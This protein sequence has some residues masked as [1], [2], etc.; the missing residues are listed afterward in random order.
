MQSRRKEEHVELSRTV[1]SRG[2]HRAAAEAGPHGPYPVSR[3]EVINN[4]SPPLRGGRSYS[5]NSLDA[6]RRGGSVRDRMTGSMMGRDSYGQHL[7]SVTTETARSKSPLREQMRKKPHYEDEGV[8]HRK[9]DYVEPVG[10]DDR[11][12]SRARG[13]YHGTSRMTKEKDYMDNRVST[14]DGHVMMSQ[15]L[16]PVEE[17]NVRGPHRLPQD[18][19]TSLNF[20]ET[21]G[22]LPFSS[23]DINIGQYEHEK[24]RHRETIPSKKATVMDSY[25][26]DKPMFDSQDVTYSMVEAS[27]SKDFMSTNQLKDF[28]STSSGLPRTEF[29]CSYQ[30]DA[31]LHVSEEYLRSS[32]KLTE[33]VGYNKYDQ[34]PLT[35]SV[36]DPESARRNMTLYQQ[37]TNSPSRAEYEDYVYRKPRV[38]GS[39]NHGYPV[40]DV[41]RMMPSQ[42]R[43]SYEHASVDYGHIGM[44]KPNIMHH[45]VDRIDNTDHSYGSSRKAIIWDDHALQK[46]IS[47]DYIDMRGSYAPMHGEE[48]VGSEDAHVAFGRRLPQDYEMS[49][50][51]A[52]HNRQLSNLRSDSGYGRG[53]GPV[54]QNE[55][56]INSSA[57]KYDA[58]QRRPGLRTKRMEGELDMYSDRILKRKFLMVEDIDR[59]SSKTIVSRKLHS[60]GDFGSSYDSEDQIDEDIIGLHA[61]RTK[62]YGHNEYRKAGRTYDGQEHQGDSELDDWYMSEGSLA[63]SQRVPIR[64]YK[65]SGKYIKGNPGPGSL[66]WHTSNHNDRRSNLHNQNKVWKRNEDY[67]EDI[68]A[69][70]GDMTEDLVN[71]AEAELSE[72]SEE[73]KQLV[74]EAFLKYS[75]KLN[76]NQSARRRYKEQGNAGSLFCIVCGKSYSKEFMDTQRLVTHAFMSHKVGLRAEHL[77][78]HKAVCVLLGWDSIAPPDTITWVPQVLP[79]AE[80]LAQKED[81]V[82]WPP[83]VVIHN[84]SMANNN[85][86]EQKVVPIEGVQAFLRGKG[87]VGGKITVCL[88]RPADQSV[89]VVKFL[90]T[91][92]GLAM[93]ERLHKYFVE[94]KRGRKEFTSKNKGDEEMGKPD[95]GEEQL[96]Y[97]YMGVSEDLDKLDFHN[98]KWSVVKSKKEIL[99]L[100]NDPVKTDER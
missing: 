11:T 46:Q 98:R 86:Q 29:L 77:G 10:F 9:Y 72:D 53:V 18:L 73:F 91:F 90:G 38:I 39:N 79:E 20:S 81:L 16:L 44:P 62:R 66:S 25:K 24:F 5:P 40:E 8:V 57:S 58:E 41:K 48:Y 17:I 84:I 88:G 61:S 54:F 49:H 7:G 70:D 52:S 50:L 78:L 56:M 94:N 31:P 76:L 68:N 33:P 80:A 13:V 100:A 69:N 36:R 23:Q 82:L 3:R 30:D 12:N 34:R 59:P 95:E 92:T 64:F 55:R 22:Q 32:R 87:F 67:D 15:K 65:N 19:G 2:Q 43:V 14:I 99:D 83:I 47:T 6:S 1:K 85:P 75:R 28:G 42:S 71:Y 51:D 93:A 27:Q 21:S 97:G 63:H 89:M 4:R 45:V 74:H 35:D 96:L 26:E 60:A 37:W